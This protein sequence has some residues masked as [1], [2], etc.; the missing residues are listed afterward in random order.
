MTIAPTRR[1]YA[2]G[3]FLYQNEE[4]H[5]KRTKKEEI[6]L[7]MIETDVSSRSSECKIIEVYK[8]RAREIEYGSIFTANADVANEWR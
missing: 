6:Y 2:M 8:A 4:H 5:L 3:S 1:L 7:F